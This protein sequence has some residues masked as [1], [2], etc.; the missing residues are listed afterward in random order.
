MALSLQALCT[1]LTIKRS[2]RVRLWR[3][4][5]LRKKSLLLL[6]PVLKTG[7]ARSGAQVVKVPLS[8]TTI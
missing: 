3:K 1:T 5:S 4:A 8:T 2:S 6:I 7:K